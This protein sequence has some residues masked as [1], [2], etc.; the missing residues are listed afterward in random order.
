M[1]S[2]GMKRVLVVC[3]V[4][5]VGVFS[6]SCAAAPPEAASIRFHYSRFEPA[7]V[8]VRA[9]TRVTITLRNDDPI[10]L[11]VPTSGA[12]FPAIPHLSIGKEKPVR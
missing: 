11:P 7:A 8:S 6:T 1:G 10:E 3:V 5:L 12:I 2:S 9:G 4:L